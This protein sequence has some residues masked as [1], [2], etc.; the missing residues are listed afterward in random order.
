MKGRRFANRPAPPS[1]PRV[2]YGTHVV[3]EWIRCKPEAVRTLLIAKG[4]DASPAVRA[5]LPL[6]ATAAIPVEIVAAEQL[7]ELCRTERHQGIVARCHAFP[8]LT[9]DTVLR[10]APPLLLLIDHLQDPRNFGA[11]LR[12][13]EAVGVGAVILP[14]DGTVPITAAVEIAAAGA[15]A[16]VK[17]CRV[18]NLVRAIDSLKRSNY[19]VAGLDARQ[20]RSI[21]DAELPKPLALVIGGETGI[22]RLVAANCD[23]WLSIPM[24]GGGESLNASVAAAVA[25]YEVRRRWLVDVGS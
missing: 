18:T 15:G 22:R 5:L 25:L 21:F 16:H 6:A 23:L 12:T 1:P 14:R 3:S 11:I 4:S 7:T 20:G 10:D 17:I 13:A 24:F 9:L 19:W 2:I 8:Y